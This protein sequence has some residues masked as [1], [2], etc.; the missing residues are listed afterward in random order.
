MSSSTY[1]SVSSE[2]K[3][4]NLVLYLLRPYNILNKRVAASIVHTPYK[5][6]TRNKKN[7]KMCSTPP[8]LPASKTISM[9]VCGTA[10][11]ES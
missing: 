10:A 4:M 2:I 6:P 5:C 8:P 3:N 11:Y 1:Q 9:K 7:W